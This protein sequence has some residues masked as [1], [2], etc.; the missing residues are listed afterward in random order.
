M[1][2]GIFLLYAWSGFVLLSSALF[3]WIVAGCQEFVFEIGSARAGAIA[4]VAM[5]FAVHLWWFIVSLVDGILWVS[6]LPKFGARRFI[7]M[8]LLVSVGAA[9]AIASALPLLGTITSPY[10][11]ISERQYDVIAVGALDCAI[12][13][14]NLFWLWRFHRN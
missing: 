6:T 5:F 9:L 14:L 4:L 3:A 1:S 13:L 8:P 7:W 12:V 10:S 11:T 2:A